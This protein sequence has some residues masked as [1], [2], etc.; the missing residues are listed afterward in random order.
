MT[1]D[2]EDSFLETL[3]ADDQDIPLDQEMEDEEAPQAEGKGKA[4]K[5][6]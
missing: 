3:L 6:L 1:L 2:V 4:I 5:M